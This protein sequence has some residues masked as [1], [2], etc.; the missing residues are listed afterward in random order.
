MISAPK[1]V[2]KSAFVLDHVGRFEIT[3]A[4][5][6]LPPFFFSDPGWVA[7]TTSCVFCLYVISKKK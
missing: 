4:A 1:S 6:H 5:Y 7:K 3:M 2:T